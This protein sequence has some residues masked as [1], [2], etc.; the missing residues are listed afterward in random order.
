VEPG[1]AV[2]TSPAQTEAP[3]FDKA[4]LMA[5]LM[6]DE[7]LARIVVDGFL[8]D[9]PKLI[10]GLGNCLRAGDAQGAIRQAHTIKGASA[11][12]G[13]E[14]LRAVAQEIENAAT[15]GDLDGVTA[16]LPDLESAFGRLREAMSE[17][18]GQTGPEPEESQ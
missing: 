8:E 12:V 6:D 4:G 17:F 7:E 18:A 11:T 2:R 5:R 14:A 13:G 9:A 16:H 1:T 10:E 3:V 15:A